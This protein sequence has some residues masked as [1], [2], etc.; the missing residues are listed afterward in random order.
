MNINSSDDKLPL[1]IVLYNIDLTWDEKDIFETR[2]V[3]DSAV[4]GVSDQKFDVKKVEINDEKSLS[5]ELGKIDPKSCVVINLCDEI[6]GIPHSEAQ[7]AR[8]LEISGFIFTGDS[9]RIIEWCYDKQ[10]VKRKVAEINL[11]TP[12]WKYFKKGEPVEWSIFPAIVKTAFEHCS[13]GLSSRSVVLNQAE[14]LEQVNSVMVH[15]DKGVLVEDFIEGREFHITV[16]GNDQITVLPIVEMDF[17]ALTSLKDQLCTY[18]AKFNA[19][20]EA[21]NKI[22]TLIP[23]PID[24][25]LRNRLKND[26]ISCYKKLGLRDNARFDVR[27][28]GEKIYFLDVNPNPDL[29]PDTSTILAAEKIGLS[30]GQFLKRMI[31][32]T[33]KRSPRFRRRFHLEKS[34]VPSLSIAV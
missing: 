2:S 11:N 16:F 5:E 30:Y 7:V 26:C 33:I 22:K 19:E 4:Q 21:Y 23:A 32:E 12:D 3:A 25:Q 6:P 27:L 13:I 18:D 29:S 20:S 17:S 8:F 24:K 1:I 15:F 9:S 31:E 28:R 10:K 34:P 14:L